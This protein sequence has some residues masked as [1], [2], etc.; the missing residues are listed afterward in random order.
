[1]VV[2]IVKSAMSVE[3]GAAFLVLGTDP[4]R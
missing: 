2:E 4:D 1:L 3:A